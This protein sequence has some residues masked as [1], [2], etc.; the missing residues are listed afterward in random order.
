MANQCRNNHEDANS[1]E[2]RLRV[3]IKTE[4]SSGARKNMKC[5]STFHK[6]L[7]KCFYRLG[8]ATANYPGYFIIT[9]FLICILG[10]TGFQRSIFITDPEV[11]Y[12]PD[13]GPALTERALI[14]HF[15]PLNSSYHF[16]PHY[17]TRNQGFGRVLI[18]PKDH[19][20]IFRNYLWKEILNIN[21]VLTNFTITYE[22]KSYSYKDLCAIWDK[23]CIPNPVLDLYD[24]V[25]QIENGFM[26]LNYPI[27][28][29]PLVL[30]M[31]FGGLKIDQN[32]LY[33]KSAS[34]LSL[35]YFLKTDTDDDRERALL[36]QRKFVSMT[37]GK[38]FKYLHVSSSSAVSY[39]ETTEETPEAV[40]PYIP[41]VAVIMVLFT[42]T[43]TMMLDWVRS[44]F[45]FGFI[46]LLS[47]ALATGASFGYLM[48]IGVPNCGI[49]YISPFLIIGIGLDDMFVTLAAWRRTR[50]QDSVEKRLGQTYA[51]AGLSILITSLTNM[52]SF[53]IGT[54]APVLS[55]KIFCLYT[56]TSILVMYLMHMTFFGGCLAVF[57]CF[58]KE[59]RH[60]ICFRKVKAKSEIGENPNLCY[61]VWCSGGVNAQ[62]PWNEKD[63]KPH[64]IMIFFRDYLGKLLTKSYSKFCI[65]MVFMVYLMLSIYGILFISEGYDK[66]STVR[67]DSYLY[68]YIEME[69]TLFRHHPYNIQVVITG[70]LKYANST[71]RQE[72]MNLHHEYEQ[73]P[74]VAPSPLTLSWMRGWFLRV[75]RKPELRNITDE[76]EFIRQ[77]RKTYLVGSSNFRAFDVAYNK[78]YSRIV[79]SRFFIQTKDIKDS[80]EDTQMMNRLREIA[81][82]NPLNVTVFNPNFIL[83]DQANLVKPAVLQA[84]GI[85]TVSMII[86]SL[87]LIPNKWCSLYIGFTIVSI[88]IGVIGFMSLW[89]VKL[90]FIS[91]ICLVMCIGFSVDFTAHISYSY[92]NSKAKTS[93]DKIMETLYALG[94]PIVQSG[95]STIC[96]IIVFVFVPAYVY[97]YFFKVVFLVVLF[98]GL[99]GL[100]LVPVLLTVAGPDAFQNCKKD[101]KKLPRMKSSNNS[102]NNLPELRSVEVKIL[103]EDATMNGK[104]KSCENIQDNL[105]LKNTVGNNLNGCAIPN[106]KEG[107]INNG[108]IV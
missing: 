60:S 90:S 38:D 14:E 46:G 10:L 73:L 9:P 18:E 92:C 39:E 36:W 42:V 98:A 68:D 80:N 7:N 101:K 3:K 78:D 94:L 97:V 49:N 5:F 100:F 44:K 107:I 41:V 84:T 96:S 95:L 31:F 89:N 105:E 13:G 71:V 91:L 28:I 4:Q 45:Y 2:R 104:S 57:G 65:L 20:S 30:P 17:I 35:A 77:L 23:K 47:A 64:L 51:D 79:A 21:E 88:E 11:L 72:I 86:I 26:K 83:F 27:M 99:H 58:E 33:I 106:V 24:K 37:E 43:N 59:Q 93:N 108:F 8:I 50:L 54:S 32:G 52:V 16:L 61:S 81:E 19:G 12:Y 25:D 69:E 22:G 76:R 66:P 103:N 40:Y 70:D 87:I 74:F 29:F 34:A 102:L 55:I 63:N 6:K 48:H 56:A 53:L 62:D 75:R 82:K 85:A 15:F 1:P 67:Y